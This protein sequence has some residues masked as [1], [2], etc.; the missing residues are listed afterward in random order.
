MD[1]FMQTFFIQCFFYLAL[2]LNLF[3][4][5]VKA[6][7][8]TSDLV[9]IAGQQ[10]MLVHQVL[11]SY[12][13]IGQ[14]QSFG[15]P[16]GTKLI[17]INHFEQNLSTLD[18]QNRFGLLIDNI[19]ILWNEFKTITLSRP[20]REKVKRLIQLN[21]EIV[22]LANKIIAILV[23]EKQNI[24]MDIINISGQQR[25]LSQRIALFMLLDNWEL[26]ENYKQQMQISLAH[27]S[28]N[29][30][31]LKANNDNT[32][33]IKKNLRSMKKDYLALIKIISRD[34]T[35]RDY[36]FAISRYTSQLLRK[37][38]KTTKL[39]VKLRNSQS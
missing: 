32:I 31:R 14:V 13:Q 18:A 11:V 38:K 3:P 33:Q 19:K 15:N 1:I 25:M 30:N 37:A 34:Q 20:K 9:N 5:T 7:I 22:S 24:R 21:E 29:L 12:A 36:S 10:R 28:M 23:K 6:N 17:A 4:S 39:Y 26:K 27:F 16:V 2:S 8:T 35:E